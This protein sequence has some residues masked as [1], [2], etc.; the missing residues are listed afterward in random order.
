[1]TFSLLIG[2]ILA[3]YLLC[4][5]RLN[6]G[7]QAWPR[8]QRFYLVNLAL[9]LAAAVLMWQIPSDAS[10]WF[11]AS[12][13][14]GVMLV[15]VSFLGWIL[16]RYAKEY[17][18]GEARL[19]D[20]QR[21]MSLALASVV[22]LVTTNHLLVLLLAW[23]AIGLS[24]HRLLMFYPERPRAVLAAHKQFLFARLAEVCLLLAFGLL[25][26]QQQ[27]PWLTEIL[28]HYQETDALSTLDEWVVMLLASAALIKC[29]Q[30]PV[31][32]W[33]I[34]VVESPT[35]VSALLHAGIINLG[36]VLLLLFA[37]LLSLSVWAKTFLLIAAGL[38]TVLAALIMHT[39][40]SIKVKLAWSTVSQMG[41]L[42]LECALGLYEIALLHLVA[43]SCYKS[44]AFLNAGSAV[45]DYVV[46]KLH[47][48]ARLS[49]PV[50]AAVVLL[51]SALV[52]GIAHF[53]H[54][55]WW[56][57]SRLVVMLPFFLMAVVL[58]S[59]SLFGHLRTLLQSLVLLMVLGGLYLLQ[60]QGFA[61]L[62]GLP[63]QVLSPWMMGWMAALMTTL[64]AGY[65]LLSYQSKWSVSQ[66]L[67]RNLYAG[68][69]LDEWA[70][71][72]T[73]AV[74]PVSLPPSLQRAHTQF[75][76]VEGRV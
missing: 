58:L 70:T 3:G 19:N 74:W 39:R 31:H 26:W 62:L 57:M 45:E 54:I 59:Q 32:G 17:L 71:R 10:M 42:L 15:L 47:R 56:D 16:T 75:K 28:A 52:L 72:L 63:P 36:G 29:A 23:I 43:H 51:A 49:L 40:S 55:I 53:M 73:L 27:T 76:Q 9:A 7:Q 11:H 33:L 12:A 14:G 18:R 66:R 68:F 61:E 65:Y 8:I 34:Q 48:P 44:F 41:L 60:K 64:F 6:S 25:W 38:S 50:L 13:V 30:L 67:Y 35:P 22:L 4:G 1:M 24:L 69:Y 2:W 5:Y 20:F 46:S 21:Y 37:P